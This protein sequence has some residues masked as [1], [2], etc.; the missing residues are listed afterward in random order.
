MIGVTTR[1]RT[2]LPAEAVPAPAPAPVIRAGDGT[3]RD[4]APVRRPAGPGTGRGRRSRAAGG[5]GELFLPR[6]ETLTTTGVDGERMRELVEA[7]RAR[8]VPL[9]TLL[10]NQ[11]DDVTSEDESDHVH[12]LKGKSFRRRQNS[13]SNEDEDMDLVQ[14]GEEDGGRE[15][16]VV[17]DPACKG[18]KVG[19]VWEMHGKTYK[20]GPTGRR[21]TRSFIKTDAPVYNMVRPL[22]QLEF[23]WRC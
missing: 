18:R 7:R 4:G 22:L 1:T 6:L 9:K 21:L 19:D 8:G 5:G 13:S 11:D 14:D 10:M 3:T 17:M 12:R 2:A 15:V 23:E 16:A 20:V